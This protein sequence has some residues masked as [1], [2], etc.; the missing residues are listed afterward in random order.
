MNN[1]ICTELND[2]KYKYYFNSQKGTQIIKRNGQDWRDE[3]GDKLILAMAQRIDQLE[4][5]VFELQVSL[6]AERA[7]ENW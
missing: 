4:D 3:T 1:D 6:D 5:E 7:G 2:G